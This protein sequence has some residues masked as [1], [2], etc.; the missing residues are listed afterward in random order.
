M[1]S[2]MRGFVQALALCLSAVPAMASGEGDAATPA[3]EARQSPAEIRADSLDRLFAG[4]HRDGGQRDPQRIERDIWELWMASDSPTAEVL[5]R[6][7]AKAIDDGAP[8]EAL[9]LLNLLTRTYPDF[10]EA[11]NRRATLYF[12]MKRYDDS[13]ADIDRVLELEPRHFGALAGRGLIYQRL[14][15]YSAAAEAYREALSMNP[16]L[17]GPRD[18]LREIER[19]ERGI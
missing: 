1:V 2:G 18:A 14:K 3:A 8:E 15:N 13:L 6:Q 4:L 7:A 10:A 9:N 17:E 5:L 16:A 12:L 11:W 19:L